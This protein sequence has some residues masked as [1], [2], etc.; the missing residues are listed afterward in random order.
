MFS[1]RKLGNIFGR[2]ASANEPETKEQFNTEG[3]TTPSTPD[4]ISIKSAYTELSE[5]KQNERAEEI[6]ALSLQF[7]PSDKKGE[8][9]CS[10]A[11]P[12]GGFQLLDAEA[13]S[14]MRS[15]VTEFIKNLGKKIYS[16]DFNLTRTSF[17]IK[18]MTSRSQLE[19]QS[20]QH[21]CMPIYLN[22]AASIDDPLERMKLFI[23]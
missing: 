16:G 13:T 19:L 17:P 14:R 4:S 9:R 11:A 8:H 10:T 2:K 7:K 18:C 6:I 23:A 21:S 22:Y 1:S 5:C 15:A 20:W 12:G 3:K